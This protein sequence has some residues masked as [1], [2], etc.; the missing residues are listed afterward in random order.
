MFNKGLDF[1]KIKSY[2]ITEGIN[3]KDTYY[4]ST[5]KKYKVSTARQE[6]SYKQKSMIAY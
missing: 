4:N 3:Y 5:V 2:S 6:H 1:S